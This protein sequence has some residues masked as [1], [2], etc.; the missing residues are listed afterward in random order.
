MPGDRWTPLDGPHWKCLFSFARFGRHARVQL[1]WLHWV[2][3]IERFYCVWHAL[4]ACQATDWL[5][6]NVYTLRR[7]ARVQTYSI[8]LP[9]LN[10]S[11]VFYTLWKHARLHIDSIG[12]PTLDVSMEFDSLWRHARV[13]FDSILLSFSVSIMLYTLWRHTRV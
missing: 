5:H 2:P 8:G 10:V 6:W 12:L 11:I 9:I 13:Q 7:H 3:H 4:E 1:D